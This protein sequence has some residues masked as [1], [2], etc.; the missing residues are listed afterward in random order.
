VTAYQ[1]PVEPRLEIWSGGDPLERDLAYGLLTYCHR[2]QHVPADLAARAA[3]FI[4][5]GAFVATAPNDAIELWQQ[6]KAALDEG[7]E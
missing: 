6:I 2:R 3:L 1:L 4:L 5:V 7:W